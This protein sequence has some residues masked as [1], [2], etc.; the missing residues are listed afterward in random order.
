MKW[1][2]TRHYH[3]QVRIWAVLYQPEC[4]CLSMG[5][6]A[7]CA[8]HHSECLSLFA[9]HLMLT[10]LVL[11]AHRNESKS[12]RLQSLTSISLHSI[13]FSAYCQEKIIKGN[14]EVIWH[15][16]QEKKEQ[17]NIILKKYRVWSF[18]QSS[19]A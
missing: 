13:L 2:S 12:Y 5:M 1:Y 4:A 17:N 16:S 10:V 11:N 18:S 15:H 14:C 6:T 8:L 19:Q 3:R 7:W 9:F